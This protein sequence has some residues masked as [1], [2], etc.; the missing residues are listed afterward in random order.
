[1]RCVVFVENH[2]L[3]PMQSVLNAPMSANDAIKLLGT[4]DDTTDVVLLLV[5]R[6]AVSIPLS[7]HHNAGFYSWS[8]VPK[9]CDLIKHTGCPMRAPSMCLF[10]CLILTERL[11]CLRL[12]GNSS[13]QSLLIRFDTHH[14]IISLFNN[15]VQRFF[16]S[17]MRPASRQSCLIQLHQATLAQLLARS[18][19]FAPSA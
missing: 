17:A 2:I 3:D 18:S 13:V 8:L 1:M 14:V 10:V 5:K 12:L 11:L 6:L 7:L 4:R 9:C 16:D 15:L 19:V